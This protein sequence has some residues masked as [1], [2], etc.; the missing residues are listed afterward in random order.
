MKLNYDFTKTITTEFG[1]GKES[2]AGQAFVAMTVDD[3]VQDALIAMA[4][5]TWE[6]MGESARSPEKYDPSEKHGALEYLYLPLGDNL[7]AAMRDLHEATNLRLDAQ[8][9]N[10]TTNIFCYFAKFE[11]KYGNRLTGLRRA[12]QFK[13]ALKSRFVRLHTNALRLVPDRLFKLDQDFDLLIEST[14]LHILRPSGFEFAG[15][16]Q[17]AIMGAVPKNIA[18]IQKELPFVEFAGIA[19]YA[20]RHPRAARYLASIQ[21]QDEGKN[22]DKRALKALCK[23]TGVAFQ[24]VDGK[25][26]VADDHV[27]GFLQLIDRRR[28]EIELV[29]GSPERFTAASRQRIR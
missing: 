13:G 12:T 28:Y 6:E 10:D 17:E 21:S 24:E 25:I 19:A 15:K 29:K 5:M 8:A 1:V 23:R 3:G 4:R 9:L 2:N 11:D 22:I 16:L 18:T 27:I 7:A 26:K 14:K 20:K